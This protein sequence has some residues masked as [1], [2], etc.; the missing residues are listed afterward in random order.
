MKLLSIGD[1]VDPGRYEFHSRFNR[2]VNF[3]N[4]PYLV[5]VVDETIGPGPLNIV[6][7]G[8]PSNEGHSVSS[9]LHI[10]PNAVEFE[11]G[12][13]SF[14][15]RDYYHSA[16]PCIDWNRARFRHN[17]SL[18]GKLLVEISSPRSLAFLL[19][20]ARIERLHS[21][22]ERAF[23]DQMVKS[24]QEMFHGDLLC[25]IRRLKGCGFGL[26]PSGDDFIAGVLVGLNLLQEMYRC[27]LRRTIDAVSTAAL[28]HNV[29][30]NTLLSL[31]QEGFLFGRMK[32]LITALAQKNEGAVMTATRQLL[33]IG[34]SSGADLGTGFFMTVRDAK[35]VITRWENDVEERIGDDSVRKTSTLILHPAVQME[36]LVP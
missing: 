29:F 14:T 22:H 3:T 9:P 35:R 18:F 8:L 20:E 30:S 21:G 31:A 24:V 27:S 17:L 34:A 4:G 13:V 5:S 15:K 28:G 19:D 2:V 11:N 16:I 6:I 23:A 36:A 10:G 32:N 25:G 26:T 12:R 7:E 33:A 1:R